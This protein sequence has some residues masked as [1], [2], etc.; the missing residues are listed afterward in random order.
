[1]AN[2]L[3]RIW[4]LPPRDAIRKALRRVRAQKGYDLDDL[5]RS[6][7]HMNSQLFYNFLSRYESILHRSHGWEAFVFEGQDV[8]EVG[9]GPVLGFGPLAL[10]LGATSYTGVDPTFQPEWALHPRLRDKYYLGIYKDLS[11]IFGPR[12][13]YER[14]LELLHTNARVFSATIL[15]AD[16]AGRS[17]GIM[18]SN[19]TIEHVEPL[20]PSVARLREL[21][22]PRVRF[23]HLVDFG[24]HRATRSPFSG[25]YAVEP[26]AY[27]QKY[28]RGINL[29]RPPDVLQIFNEAGFS[30]GMQPYYWFREFFDEPILPYWSNRY[31]DDDLFLKCAIVFSAGR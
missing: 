22:A 16:L 30:A 18:L 29:A 25:I 3:R 15:D 8:L 10:F 11:G 27:R 17:F 6:S 20:G 19:S 21:A 12:M 31:S 7:K 28:G 1:M 2:L 4:E 23:I 24:N 26:D 14:W 13:T 5:L 9:C